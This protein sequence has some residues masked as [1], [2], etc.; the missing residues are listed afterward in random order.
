M[1]LQVQKLVQV[2]VLRDDNATCFVLDQH[3]DLGFL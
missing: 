3:A 1:R 2:N